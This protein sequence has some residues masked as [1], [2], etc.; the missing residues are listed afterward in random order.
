[1]ELVDLGWTSSFEEHFRGVAL[2]EHSPA[3]VCAIYNHL[4]RLLTVEGDCLASVSGR[5]RH[6]AAGAPDF[7]ATGDWVAASKAP[8]EDRATI[9][10][11]LPRASCFSRKAAGSRTGEQVVAANVD[12]VFLVGGLDGDF[13]PRRLERTLV[14][15]WE[16]GA[17]PVIVLT[18]A[19]LG[20]DVAERRRAAEEA[21]AGVPVI[22]ISAATGEGLS[23]LAPYL[24][25]GRTVALLGSSGVGK[26]T[27]VNRLLGEERQRTLA[28]RARDDRGRH[29]TT[30]RELIPLP[31]GALV[32]DTPGLREIQLWASE[33]SLNDTFA[34][35]AA[36]A[37]SCRFRDCGHHEEPGCAVHAAVT[38]GRLAPERLESHRKLEKELRSL[39]IRQDVG[40]QSA[41]KAKWR[42]VHRQ[43][44]HHRPRE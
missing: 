30:H 6:A 39:E 32:I 41:Q 7:P 17:D 36:L 28:V 20:Q 9:H 23:A 37:T 15:A 12:T 34:D 40:L 18:K 43:A 10:A 26:S 24:V 5:L 21:A 14:L 31:G 4:L 13:N 8:G 19:D 33:S 27:L 44:R 35:L 25:R 11:V 22:V 1:M 3:R 29:A 16:S 38:E 2:P 42:A